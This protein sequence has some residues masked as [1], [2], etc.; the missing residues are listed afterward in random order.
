MLP[1]LVTVN[2]RMEGLDERV[3]VVECRAREVPEGFCT[4]AAA[5][6]ALRLD[7][8]G[9][10]LQRGADAAGEVLFDLCGVYHLRQH[11]E[12]A[13]V[14]LLADERE[15]ETH[16]TAPQTRTERFRQRLQRRLRKAG[17]SRDRARATAG[18]LVPRPRRRHGILWRAWA[19]LAAAVRRPVDRFAARQALDARLAAAHLERVLGIRRRLSDAVK[20]AQTEQLSGSCIPGGHLI[21]SRAALRR[22]HL[23]SGL[24]GGVGAGDIGAR[25][26]ARA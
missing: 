24:R 12:L 14:Q 25:I 15:R 6:E 19:R 8:V 21:R 10:V 13:E 5:G 2:I 17:A 18:R 1:H 7:A 9:E 3:R 4:S 20:T 23:R 26:R 22:P 16:T 11:A